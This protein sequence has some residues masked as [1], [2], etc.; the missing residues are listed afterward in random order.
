MLRPH[1]DSSPPGGG[2]KVP[3]DAYGAGVKLRHAMFGQDVTDRQ[4]D[5]ANQFTRPMQDVVS[6][7]CFGETWLREGLSRRDRSMVTLAALCAMGRSHE[8]KIH[9]KGALA[10]GVTPLEIRELL[11]HTMVYAGVPLGV[12]GLL[13]AAESLAEEGVD[14]DNVE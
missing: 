3:D 8:L 6:K 12:T 2:L 7:Y 9:V 14:L 4:I 10:N 1:D 13:S 11:L 5:N